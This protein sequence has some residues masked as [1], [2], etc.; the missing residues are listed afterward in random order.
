LLFLAVNHSLKLFLW[1]TITFNKVYYFEF[2][3]DMPKA[4]HMILLKS[5]KDY[6]TNYWLLFEQWHR[7]KLYITVLYYA[8][9]LLAIYFYHKK[10]IFASFVVISM[11]IMTSLRLNLNSL[12]YH[13]N[14][15]FYPLAIFATSYLMW[16]LYKQYMRKKEAIVREPLNLLLLIIGSLFMLNVVS[17]SS[18]VLYSVINKTSIIGNDCPDKEIIDRYTTSNDYIWSGPLDFK[19]FYCT[20]RKPASKYTF[21]LPWHAKSPDITRELIDDL[22]INKPKV[23]I[24]NENQSIWRIKFRSYAKELTR[25]IHNNYRLVGTDQKTNKNFYALK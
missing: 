7:K 11:S 25:F 10:N 3:K 14:L 22:R 24:L 15:V 18:N 16:L 13:G 1:Q 17:A 9:L 21:Y 8:H 23:I 2:F 4:T 12:K 5:I 19:T 6:I 20:Q